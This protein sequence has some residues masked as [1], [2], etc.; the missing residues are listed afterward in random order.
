MTAKELYDIIQELAGGE[1]S[2][3][4][5]R[6]M[7]ELIALASAEGSRSQGGTF[8]NLFSQV[9]FVCQHLGVKA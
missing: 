4:N 9:D 7:H 2:V 1:P 3:Q 5:L 8:G 6:Q